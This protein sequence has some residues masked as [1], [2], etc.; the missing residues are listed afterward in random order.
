M[1]KKE[2]VSTSWSKGTSPTEHHAP[3]RP[4]PGPDSAPA[5]ALELQTGRARHATSYSRQHVHLFGH[6]IVAFCCFSSL[7]SAHAWTETNEGRQN[8]SKT[9]LRCLGLRRIAKRC[10]GVQSCVAR[11]VCSAARETYIY[12]YWAP[13]SSPQAA[14]KNS[15]KRVESS[16]VAS[17]LLIPQ[18]RPMLGHFG[19]AA[20]CHEETFQQVHL[21]AGRH[22]LASVFRGNWNIANIDLSSGSI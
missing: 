12:P 16:V 2:N 3:D 15:T 19:S 5:R 21:I 1:P 8:C 11:C 13:Q 17:R 18:S 6:H 10:V 4:L 20:S 9:A 7:N 14:R 22:H